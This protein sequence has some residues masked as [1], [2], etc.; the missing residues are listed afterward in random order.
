MAINTKHEPTSHIAE[1][2]NG[3]NDKNQIEGHQQ[4]FSCETPY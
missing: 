3:I 4:T 2:L 1:Q